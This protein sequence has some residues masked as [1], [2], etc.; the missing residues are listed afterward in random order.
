MDKLKYKKVNHPEVMEQTGLS[1]LLRTVNSQGN[2]DNAFIPLDPDNIDYQEY[3]E[4]V[5]LG[6]TAEEAD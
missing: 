6:N 4:W 5:G 1:G 2:A 3:L